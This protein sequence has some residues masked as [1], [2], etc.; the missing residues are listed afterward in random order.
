MTKLR[1]QQPK[2]RLDPTQNR[3]RNF[4]SSDMIRIR[5]FAPLF[6]QSSGRKVQLGSG[7][8]AVTIL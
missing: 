1:K 3:Q 7:W 5:R 6:Y 4:K 2:L 8:A